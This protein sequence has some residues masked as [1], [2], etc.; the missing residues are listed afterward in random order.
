MSVQLFAEM[1]GKLEQKF[2]MTEVQQTQSIASL[3]VQD[4]NQDLFALVEMLFHH[5]LA[6]LFVETT[7]FHTMKNAKTEIQ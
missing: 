1:A 7:L 5:L 4:Q 6:D 2:V 3:T